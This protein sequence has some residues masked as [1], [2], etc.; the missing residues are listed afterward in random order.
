MFQSR[1][2]DYFNW[3]Y[4]DGTCRIWENKFQSRKQDYFN[5]KEKIEGENYY[6]FSKFQSRK[7][8]YFNWKL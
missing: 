6:E 7:Q 3:K 2:Q 1:K 5:W 4:D 8:D